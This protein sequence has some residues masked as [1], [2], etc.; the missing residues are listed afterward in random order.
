MK[1]KVDNDILERFD[2]LSIGI[3]ICNNLTNK[4]SGDEISKAFSSEKSDIIK[5][6]EGI[7]LST[8]PIIKKWRQIYKSFGEKKNR[9]SVEALI[10]R[11]L[12]G[13]EIPEINPLVDIYNTA[14]LK[15]ELPCG[16]EDLAKVTEDIILGIASGE[17]NFLPL[18]SSELEHPTEGEIVYKSGNVILCGSFNYRE[19]D[20]TKL[21]PYTQN[22][23]LVIESALA[24]DYEKLNLMLN[25]LKINI[26]KY[27]GGSCKTFILDKNTP[28][29]NMYK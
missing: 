23:V 2:P 5:R 14:S 3:I 13:K 27:L 28:E 6:F 17:E 20:I 11:T 29:I 12:N 18:G 25:Y 19:S 10:R 21:T 4:Y 24:E 16:G 9:C 1:F 26:E 8:Y 22:A 7:E 15:F